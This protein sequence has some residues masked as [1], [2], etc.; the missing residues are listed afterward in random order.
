MERN[1]MKADELVELDF[2]TEQKTGIHSHENFELMFIISGKMVMVIQEEVYQLGAGDMLV[3]NTERKHNYNGSEDL[4]AARFLIS[5]V[6]VRELLGQ[7][8]VFFWCNSTIDQNAAYDDLRRTITGIL[9]YELHRQEGRVLYVKS[10][11][12][13]MLSI[14]TENFMLTRQDLRSEET[15]DNDD[16]IDEIFAYVRANFR[17]NITL[18]DIGNYLY[19]SPAYV[20]RYIKKRCNIN[21]VE[22]LNTVRLS[23]AMEDLMYTDASITKI[24]L[25][26][27]FA[28]VAAYNKVFKDTHGMTPSQFRR[29]R[30]SHAA[31]A[32]HQ[33]QQTHDKIRKTV[34]HFLKRNPN[35]RQVREEPVL[36]D[37]QI[38]M[39]AE[40]PC[41]WDGYCCKMINA[42]T[43]SNLLNAVFQQ[44]ILSCRSL[45]GFTYVRFWDIYAPDLYLDIHIDPEMQNYNR[46]NEVTDFLIRN[47]MKPYI[48]LGF[49]PFRIHR[50]AA[51]AVVDTDRGEEFRSDAEMAAFY[52][53]LMANFVGRYGAE[54][55][56]SWYFE[57]WEKTN[58]HF[59]A[60]TGSFHYNLMAESGHKEYFRKF[61]IVA[62]AMRGVLTNTR[63][64]GGGFLVRMYGDTGFAQILTVWKNEP[65]KP[66]FLSLSC[67][68]YILERE[69][70]DFYEKK[71][72]DLEFVRHNIEM[73]N[74]AIRLAQFPE[75]ELHVSEYSLSLSNRNMINDSCLKG[76]WIVAN[77]ISCLGK[78]NL[79]GHWLFT[80]AYSDL[81]DTKTLLFGGCGLLTKNGIRKPAYFA[82]EF[83]NQLYGTVIGIH[84][85]YVVTRSRRGS[86]R[87]LC[88]N[89]KRPN[90]NYYLAEEDSHQETRLAALIEN[91]DYLTIRFQITSVEPGKY[92]AKRNQLSQTYGSVL[93][94]W[95]SL[96][97]EP[98]LTMREMEYLISASTSRITIEDI[99]AEDSIAYQ[100]VLEPNEIQYIHFQRK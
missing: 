44:Q 17:Q 12:Y 25:D 9:N 47:H 49:K 19:L 75:T 22:L 26:N 84:P 77:A 1:Y 34:E 6:K 65:Q 36:L 8:H 54:E 37:A 28:S 43:A 41:T 40:L 74:R 100:V 21:F 42:G 32:E 29:Q 87:I 66:D 69:N 95:E 18:E 11:H 52:Q 78:A 23:R 71:N 39:D 86:V 82:M 24:A 97:R 63:I 13:R 10:M 7:S 99:Q 73:A 51:K 5:A 80:D 91:R 79:I 4:V 62:G 96:N 92:K 81:Q 59:Q 88:H 30:K 48:E 57:L 20:S 94:N 46:L 70:Q 33:K 45:M 90:Y 72:T 16:R 2:V 93:D 35:I 15:R 60:D 98:S 89:L 64:G 67:Y 83:L 55:V 14:L 27:G 50:T 76:A 85:N 38:S 61:N 31:D 56:S 68:P 58:I 53:G 3:V